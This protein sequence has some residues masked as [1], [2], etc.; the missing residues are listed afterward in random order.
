[1]TKIDQEEI[2]KCKS[3]SY[4]FEHY[5]I[6]KTQDGNRKPNL[7]E[8]DRAKAIEALIETTKTKQIILS[9]GGRR[10]FLN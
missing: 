10:S 6:I 1:M 7:I 2:E 8:T 3:F 4:F 9:G 5:C